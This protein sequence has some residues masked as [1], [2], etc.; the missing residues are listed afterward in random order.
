MDRMIGKVISQYQ[1]LEVLGR[2]GMGV[3]YRAHD[4]LLDR[5][6]ALKTMDVLMASDPNFLRRF[7][8]EARALA[9]LNDPNI[10]S[11]FNLLETPDGVCIAMEFVKGRTLGEF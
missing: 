5:D 1:I 7:Q 10:V 9:R 8:S 4:T 3:V 6:V 2:G 11:V